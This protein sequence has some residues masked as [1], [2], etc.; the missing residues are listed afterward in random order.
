MKGF[1]R[2]LPNTLCTEKRLV[3]SAGE[4]CW[5]GNSMGRYIR[6]VVGDGIASQKRNPEF[7][8]SSFIGSK[9]TFI[10]ERIQFAILS[11][12]LTSLFYGQPLIKSI[13]I[14][15][16]SGSKPSLKLKN[17]TDLIEGSGLPESFSDDEDDY[18]NE[19]N[20]ESIEDSNQIFNDEMVS[21][22]ILSS[23]S[24]STAESSQKP[25]NQPSIIL[26]LL[27]YV[28]LKTVVR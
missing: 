21:K 13:E 11:K 26:L 20:L 12:K 15:E 25:L 23:L 24:S 1:F 28:L 27:L 2:S 16:G 19:I 8:T 22:N 14:Y 17:S 4:L 7:L 10:D 5:N 3:A 18:P 9:E 6:R